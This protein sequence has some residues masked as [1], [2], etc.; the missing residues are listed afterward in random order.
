[1]KGKNMA[2]FSFKWMEMR[3]R[4]ARKIVAG[5]L[6]ATHTYFGHK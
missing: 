6:Y 3:M 1:M 2:I 4:D 5:V